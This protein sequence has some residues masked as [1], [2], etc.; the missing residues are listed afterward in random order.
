MSIVLRVFNNLTPDNSNYM[1]EY[2]VLCGDDS[3]AVLEEVGQA[4]FDASG[5]M[6]RLV[7]VATDITERKKAEETLR[8]RNED[9]TRFNN[10]A[11]GRELRMIELKKEINELC[12][13]KGEPARYKVDFDKEFGDEKPVGEYLEKK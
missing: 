12:E 1:A 11:V 13:S 9:L 8:R 7:G 3:V 10:Y 4:A 6:E 5:K 2:R